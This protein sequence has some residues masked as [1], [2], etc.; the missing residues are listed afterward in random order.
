MI[1]VPIT[2]T[3]GFA[4]GPPREVTDQ[5]QALPVDSGTSYDVLPDGTGFVT[6]FSRDS[7]GYQRIRVVLNWTTEVNRK[8]GVSQ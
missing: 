6:T 7:P 1:A 5:Y 2:T 3:G 8:M 4:A